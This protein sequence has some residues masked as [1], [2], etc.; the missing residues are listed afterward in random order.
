MKRRDFITLI[1]SMAV[2][3]P[4]AANAQQ[5]AKL[6]LIGVLNP[7]STE[8]PGAVRF[9]EGLRELGYTEGLNIA[10]ERRYGDSNTDRFQQLA[11]DLVRLKVDV[12]VVMS[13]TPARAAKQATSTIPIAVGGMADPVGDELIVSLARP[14]GN[15]TGNTFLGPEFIAK[16]FELLKD[17]ISGLSRVAALWHPSAYGKR[18]MEGMIKETEAA[19]QALGLELQLVPV[20]GPGELDAAFVTMT[21][22]H[23]DAVIQ[24]PSP[25]L[26]GEHKRIVELAA[27]GR[28]AAMYAAREFVEDGGLMSYGPSQPNLFR[29]LATY[30]DKILKGANPAD[31]PVEQP[32][33]LEFVI[34]LKTAK[35]LG[36]VIPREFLVMVDEVIE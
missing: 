12:I 27:K 11:A 8:T 9:Y 1:G 2:A 28:L 22:E 35:E 16:R 29:R 31:L 25:M 4:L 15:I 21:R 20:L 13:T 24:L 7:G 36:L 26:F 30:V 18:T 32:T 34:N 33:V 10:I 3:W 5:K 14:G 6:P 17:A 23:A 19:A